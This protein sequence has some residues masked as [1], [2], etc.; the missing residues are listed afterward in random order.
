MF[1]RFNITTR[2]TFLILLLNGQNLEVQYVRNNSEYHSTF[3]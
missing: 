1:K 2:I 3:P